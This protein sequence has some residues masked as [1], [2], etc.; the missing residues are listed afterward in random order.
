MPTQ[1]II[2]ASLHAEVMRLRSQTNPDTGS[3]WSSREVSRWLLETHGLKA[4]RM[5]VVRLEAALTKKGDALIAQA[6]RDEMRDEVGPMK[7]RLVK[8]ARHLAAAIACEEDTSKIAAGVRALTGVVD[9][10]SKLGGIA[11]PMAVDLMSQGKPIATL[12]D[13]Q[14][15]ARIA[16]LK[17]RVEG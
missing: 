4:S 10:F 7:I 12:T 9:A 15:V 5:A 11:A 17:A 16:E 8:S 2:P 6:L 13:D 3:P 14:L 1:H